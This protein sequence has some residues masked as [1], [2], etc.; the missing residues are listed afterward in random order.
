M[1]REREGDRQAEDFVVVMF[2]CVISVSCGGEGN[3]NRT[4]KKTDKQTYRPGCNR[5]RFIS[6][7]KGTRKHVRVP[8]PQRQ[9][10]HPWLQAEG[11][12]K[13]KCCSS[14]QATSES[15]DKHVK[16]RAEVRSQPPARACQRSE[17]KLAHRQIGC[18]LCLS[19]FLSRLIQH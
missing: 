11:I 17:Q 9:G 18:R 12:G 14:H 10:T 3:I 6:L 19:Y 13:T 2:C 8:H 15:N 1:G 16:Q 4:S 5:V 7:M